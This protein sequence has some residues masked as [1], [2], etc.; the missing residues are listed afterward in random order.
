MSVSLRPRAL[1]ILLLSVVAMVLAGCTLPGPQQPQQQPTPTT[2]PASVPAGGYGANLGIAAGGLIH[3]HDDAQQARDLDAIAATGAKWI[4]IDIDWNAIQ[5]TG[6]TEWSWSRATDRIVSNANARG[7]RVLGG[8]AYSPAWARKAA[9]AGVK[10]CMPANPNHYAQFA[11]AAVERYGSRSPITHL[12]GGIDAWEIWN[13]P[14]HYPWV[15]PTVDTTG[16]AKLLQATYPAIKAADPTTTVVT[17]GMAPA[18]NSPG[19]EDVTPLTF[20]Q[21]IY[22]AGA[23]G[24]FD[25]VGMHPYSFPHSPFLGKEWNA[26]T[27]VKFLRTEMVLRGDGHKKIWATEAGA[28]TG[29]SDRSVGE[30]GQVQ[31]VKDYMQAWFEGYKEFAGPLFW[32]QHRDSGTDPAD[33]H[34]NLGLLRHDGRPK[35]AYAVFQQYGKGG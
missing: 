1:P 10:Y 19:G 23:G 2:L 13:E 34:Q 26:F 7:L 9:C 30:A 22:D 24:F 25:A 16:Y 17:G 27:Q 8:I 31:Q 15:R 28:P 18:P 14:N 29:T 33:W 12:R 20:L 3:W 5:T 21:R 35:P 11:K 4:R 6:P 32:F